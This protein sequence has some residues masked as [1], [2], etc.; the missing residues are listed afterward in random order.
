MS[1]R[2]QRCNRQVVWFVNVGSGLDRCPGFFLAGILVIYKKQ[3]LD[4][5]KADTE[6]CDV[7]IK[8]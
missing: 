7:M 1:D 2:F 3:T 8:N 5:S 6:R 4:V